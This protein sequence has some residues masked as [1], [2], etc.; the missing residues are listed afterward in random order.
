MLFLQSSSFC[1]NYQNKYVTSNRPRCIGLRETPHPTVFYATKTKTK[2]E[3]RDVIKESS[4]PSVIF[5]VNYEGK[6]M[7][8][9]AM[10][11]VLKKKRHEAEKQYVMNRLTRRQPWNQLPEGVTDSDMVRYMELSQ[12]D[13]SPH[14]NDK[15]DWLF[16]GGNLDVVEIQGKSF[17]AQPSMTEDFTIRLLD[18]SSKFD[19]IDLAPDQKAL[20]KSYGY[21]IL[22]SK[23]LIGI[24]RRKS[25]S[26]LNRA[27]LTSED[28]NVHTPINFKWVSNI[29]ASVLSQ[30]L[31]ILI[32]VKNNLVKSNVEKLLADSTLKL[33]TLP[34]HQFPVSLES[35]NEHV[36]SYTDQKSVNIVD[37]R[38]GRVNK[39]F[40]NENFIMNCEKIVRNKKSLHDNLF[41]VAS[42]HFLYGLDL[43]NTS[44]LLL[45]WTH[46]LELPPTKMD[47]VMYGSDEVICLSSNA[48]G[49][50]KI[51]NCS[52]GKQ[53]DSWQVNWVPLKPHN[54]RQSYHKM[55]SKGFCLLSDPIK[56]RVDL[57][58]TGVAMIAD[59][60]KSRIQLFTRNS[61]GDVFKSHLLADLDFKAKE[62]RMTKSFKA[63]EKVLAVERDPLKIVP[64]EERLEFGDLMFTDVARM[65]G[66]GKVMRCEK[67]QAPEEEPESQ[68]GV[69]RVPRWKTNLEDEKEYRDALSQHILAEWDLQIEDTQPRLF[70][71]ALNESTIKVEDGLDRVAMWLEGTEL[72][73]EVIKEEQM[74]ADTQITSQGFVPDIFST[75][76][77]DTAKKSQ[78]V[79]KRVKGF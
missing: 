72:E 64:L 56:H 30:Q 54:I 6:E 16:T 4:L 79:S 37:H 1:R 42:S 33:P 67:L 2:E 10:T 50:L 23:E 62:K 20:E 19:Y 47:Q 75:Q 38:E 11:M 61:L 32:D 77:T 44:D 9:P 17:L 28:V 40:G 73:G 78:K 3:P 15:C 29:A 71:G 13:P 22:Q 39:V 63:W 14:I 66:L 48:Q 8:D 18:P 34:E 31:L 52:K 25:I 51:F 58:V 45:H 24:R 36:V 57:S 41:Y 26:F 43:R 53:E 70:A 5:S 74:F 76:L 68:M 27:G 55:R 7:K 69:V 35:L 46:Q 60:K 21:E 59:E 12:L 49:D 65:K